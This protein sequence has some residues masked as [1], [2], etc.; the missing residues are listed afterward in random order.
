MRSV[1]RRPRLIAAGAAVLALTLST[2]VGFPEPARP[3]ASRTRRPEPQPKRYVSAQAYFHAL[4]A[5]VLTARGDDAG[6]AEALQLALVYDPESYHLT[7]WLA[8]LTWKIGRGARVERLVERAM[9]L[10]PRRAGPWLL[11]GQIDR[12]TGKL[13]RAERAFERAAQ[14]E[15]SSEEG[16][17]AAIALADS[18]EAR[19]QRDRAVQ[20]LRRAAVRAPK[21]RRLAEQLSGRQLLRGELGAAI[22]TLERGAPDAPRLLELYALAGRWREA[23]AIWRRRV[24]ATPTDPDV[25]LAAARAELGLAEQA[26]ALALIE[27]ALQHA[28]AE[29]LLA[30]EILAE[31]GAH[32]AALPL[33]EAAVATTPGGAARLRIA[34]HFAAAG[35]LPKA[36][37]L[38]ASIPADDPVFAE[39][40]DF[41]L[42]ALGI[43]GRP[44]PRTTGDG[45]HDAI[46]EAQLRAASG[47]GAA[48]IQQLEQLAALGST[49]EPLI[50]LAEVEACVGDFASAVDRLEGAA[51]TR[52]AQAAELD[53]ARALLHARAGSALRSERLA[54]ALFDK[55]PQ[56]LTAL[57]LLARLRAGRKARLREIEARLLQASLHAPS[58]PRLLA[59]R[60]R[61]LAAQGRSGAGAALLE[62]AARLEPLDPLVQE[63]LGDAL[64]ASGDTTRAGE[65]WAR[66]A[67]AYEAQARRCSPGARDRAA[68]VERKRTRTR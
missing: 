60:G 12:A 16:V 14:L 10:E 39:A 57:G 22:T 50:A 15:P 68:R 19:G 7:L 32:A 9:R 43:A 3:S 46:L 26:R 54:A 48:A 13:E 30:G 52:P 21:D 66:A 59:A 55:D 41:R 33:L 45:T 56:N 18:Y 47:D 53:L 64:H 28:P 51:L 49:A 42:Q 61:V 5:E 63:Y 1:R 37:E 27:Q 20:V 25:L 40:A 44:L 4:R 24:E 8:R 6:A 36:A 31:A 62:R 35:Q 65:A 11:R 2:R 67:A 17:E 38:A 29:R 23:A 58:D 34:K